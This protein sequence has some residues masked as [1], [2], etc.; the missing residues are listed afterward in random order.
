MFSPILRVQ[1]CKGLRRH[2]GGGERNAVPAGVR[3]SVDLRGLT[4]AC[5]AEVPHG[6]APVRVLPVGKLVQPK[7]GAI[8]RHSVIGQRSALPQIVLVVKIQRCIVAGKN[9]LDIHML[10]IG[11]CVDLFR[12]RTSCASPQGAVYSSQLP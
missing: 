1:C 5:R 2:A 9:Q 12:R 11:A 10:G 6:S 7:Q 3:H 4:V 8:V